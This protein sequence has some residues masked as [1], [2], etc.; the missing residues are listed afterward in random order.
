[1]ETFLG[2]NILMGIKPQ[3]SYRDYWRSEPNLHDTFISS[4]TIV[5]RFGWLLS[6]LHLNGNS[7]MPNAYH[8]SEYVGVDESMIKFKG[9]SSLKQILPRK[10]TIKRGYKVWMLAD[11]SGYALKFDV[12]TGLEGEKRHRVFSYF[13]SVQLIEDLKGKQITCMWATSVNGLCIVKLQ[14][15]RTVHLLSSFHDPRT[16]TV[17]QW[18]E[19]DGTVTKLPCPLLLADYIETMKCVGKFDQRKSTYETDRKSIVA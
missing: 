14:D 13:T 5:N 19:K 16:T 18:K 17:V 10:K 1:M 7:C 4:M 15:K 9:R 8:L 2:L 3:A 6:N 11:K 12:H